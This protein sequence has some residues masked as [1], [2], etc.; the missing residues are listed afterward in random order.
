VRFVLFVA[1]VVRF[2]AGKEQPMAFLTVRF[3]SESLVK[4]D[5]MNVF[6]PEGTRG[7]LP[8]LYLLHGLSDNHTAWQRRTSIERYLDGKRL[9]VVMPDTHRF[10]YVN[11]PRPGGQAYEDH[12]IRDVIGTMDRMFPTVRGRRGRAVAGLSMGGYGALM[13][14]MRHPDKFSTAVSHSGALHFAHAFPKSRGPQYGDVAELSKAL[15]RR[16]YDLWALA[17]R[18]KRS[19]RRLAIRLDCGTED[20]LIESNRTFHAHL[21][22]LGIDHEYA[23]H[24]GA[25]DWAYWDA[26]VQDTLRF[27]LRHLRAN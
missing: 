4:Q 24:S 1:F 17:R 20:G 22:R 12:I 15:P 13:L 11:D 18:L 16:A 5:A 3:R 23:E 9:I 14:A 27:V 8:V 19:R 26:H 21:T 6:F 7:R 25:H 2:P 10:F